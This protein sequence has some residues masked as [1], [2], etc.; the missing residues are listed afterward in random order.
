MDVPVKKKSERAEVEPAADRPYYV[1]NVDIFESDAGVVLLADMPGVSKESVHI[2]VEEGVLTLQGRVDFD[3]AENSVLRHREFE[4][5]D[6]RRSFRLSEE[7]D[8]EKLE[9]ELVDGVL[10]ITLPKS[11]WGKTRK[12]E[13]K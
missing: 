9:A 3:P 11:D 2:T 10:R 1:P 12:I 5:G 4:F 13:V 7:V 6:F 8:R